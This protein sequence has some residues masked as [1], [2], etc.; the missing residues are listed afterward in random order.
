MRRQ[1]GTAWTEDAPR[2]AADKDQC[3]AAPGAPHGRAAAARGGGARAAGRPRPW[4][5]AA[6]A[7][8]LK[9]QANLSGLQRRRARGRQLPPEAAGALLHEHGGRLRRGRVRERQH[10]VPVHQL[11]SQLRGHQARAGRAGRLPRAQKRRA[12]ARPCD[13]GEI[14][15][16]LL[17]PAAPRPRGMR[18]IVAQ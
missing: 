12:S 14:G 6:R 15:Q 11:T 13:C 18:S 8:I 1:P 2:Y 7:P 4:R 16:G 5:R 17:T 9:P 10:P 3:C